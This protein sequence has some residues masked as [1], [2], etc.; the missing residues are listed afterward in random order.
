MFTTAEDYHY[1]SLI[2]SG[3]RELEIL[4][5][6][7]ETND[8]LVQHDW[9]FISPFFFLGGHLNKISELRDEGGDAKENILKLI[10][11]QFFNL[12]YT[13]SFVEGYCARSNTI[14]PFLF[15]IEHSL[16]LTFQR[17]YEGAIKTLIPIIEGVIRKYLKEEKNEDVENIR[18]EKIRKSFDMMR[19]DLIN[20]YFEYI[21]NYTTE[22]NEKLSFSDI[23]IKSLVDQ[24]TQYYTIWFSFVADF[25]N[26]SFYLNTK[27]IAITNEINRHSILHEF[28]DKVEYNFENYI[29]IYFL[30]QFLTWVFLKKERKSLMNQIEGMRFYEK[31]TAYEQIIKLSEKLFYEKHL[32]YKNYEDYNKNTY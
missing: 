14:K 28:G 17:D 11:A 32:L 3:K 18:F 5:E 13:A 29:K 31:V 2:Q 25:V 8:F 1:D 15:S 12:D 20:N 27:G 24:Q 4:N 9:L 16:V 23:Q 30:L 21:K 7:K 26:Q 6:Y 22:N 10:R 19:Q